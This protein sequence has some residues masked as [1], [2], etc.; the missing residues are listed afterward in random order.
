M[1]MNDQSLFSGDIPI[2]LLRPSFTNGQ[3]SSRKKY[4]SRE[5]SSY[6]KIDD[7]EIR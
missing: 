2:R 4:S 3:A 1:A 5:R 6:C 7:T